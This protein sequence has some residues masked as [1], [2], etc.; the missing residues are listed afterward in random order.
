MKRLN[1]RKIL[2]AVQE[3]IIGYE[4]NSLYH[5]IASCPLCKIYY[6]DRKE[7]NI[8][9]TCE[10]CLNFTFYDSLSEIYPC[11]MRNNDF[12]LLDFDGENDENLARFWQEIYDLLS[13]TSYMKVLKPDQGL[14]TKILEIAE[15]YK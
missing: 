1:K 13:L 5:S 12:K 6:N 4:N 10:N 15:K 11:I 8:G 7:Y 9:V 2:E 14:K 3:L